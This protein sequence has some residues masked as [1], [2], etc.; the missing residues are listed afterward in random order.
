MVEHYR[1]VDLAGA[2]SRIGLS[3][4][5]GRFEWS[6]RPAVRG[7]LEYDSGEVSHTVGA[8]LTFGRRYGA[9]FIVDRGVL[10]GGAS[11]VLLHIGGYISF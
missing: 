11:I 2:S 9:R 7:G 4:R 8:S 5:V 1:C 3:V 6:V 10:A